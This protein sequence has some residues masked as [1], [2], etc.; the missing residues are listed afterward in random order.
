MEDKIK[1]VLK[2][3]GKLIKEVCHL[4]HE[5]NLYELGLSSHSSVNVMLALE[6][7][8]D[9]EFPDE[10]LSKKMFSS[11]KNLKSAVS[12]ALER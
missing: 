3:H 6:T 12:V 11:I 5:D 7:E 8:F 1:E 2:Q 4:N 9:M 10:V